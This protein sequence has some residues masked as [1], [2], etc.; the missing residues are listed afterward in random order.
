MQAAGRTDTGVHAQRQFVQFF[1]DDSIATPEAMPQHLNR[2][3]PDDLRVRHLRKVSPL[4][5]V[6]LHATLREYKYNLGWGYVADP[7]KR[8][9]QG[10]VYGDLDVSAM[11]GAIEAMVG[12][13]DFGAFS[14]VRHDSTPTVRTITKAQLVLLGCQEAQIQVRR[15]VLNGQRR[16]SMRFMFM[17]VK[18]RKRLEAAHGMQVQGNGFLHKMV[19]HIVGAVIAVGQ[20]QISQEYVESL[21]SQ[22]LPPDMLT[23]GFRGWRVADACGLHKVNVEFQLGSMDC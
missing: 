18:A 22:G 15:R 3:L 4:F 17:F 7:L 5:S 6:R 9:Y 12:T 11:T 1:L 14:N 20:G 8:R 23:G 2:L 19:R 21:L 16:L 13:H 10:F